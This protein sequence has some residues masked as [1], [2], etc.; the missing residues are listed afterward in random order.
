MK[1]LLILPLLLAVILTGGCSLINQ[2]K[3]PVETDQP[4]E[5]EAEVSLEPE[6]ITEV[7]PEVDDSADEATVFCSMDVQIC[8]DGSAV[9]RAAPDCEI[10]PCPSEE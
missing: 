3:A 8:P 2:P 9:G 1:K 6:V 5:V 7:I 4:I 10:L